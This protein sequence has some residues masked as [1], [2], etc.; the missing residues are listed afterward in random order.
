MSENCKFFAYLDVERTKIDLSNELFINTISKESIM[1]ECKAEVKLS[2]KEQKA[3]AEYEKLVEAEKKKVTKVLHITIMGEPK[4][5]KRERARLGKGRTFVAMYDPNTSIKKVIQDY[6]IDEMAEQG[7][8]KIMEAPVYLRVESYKKIPKSLSA[9]K[10]RLYEEKW[11]LPASKPD[12]DN[13]S[14]LFMDAA[15]S[16]LWDDDK[17]VAH[18]EAW[19]YLS[20]NPRLEIFVEFKE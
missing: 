8:S 7:I 9:A 4:A 3:Q 10:A 5:W 2:K 6:I 11:L 13:Y 14:K 15:N 20:I 19:K 12:V 17:Q 1:A 16:I 18:L